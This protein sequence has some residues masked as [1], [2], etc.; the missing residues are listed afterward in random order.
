MGNA[1]FLFIFLIVFFVVSDRAGETAAAKPVACQFF[2]YANA[3]KLLGQK[4]TGADSEENK[5][6]GSQRWNC[7]FTAS[8][9]DGG[10]KL[11]FSLYRDTTEEAARTEFQRIRISNHQGFEDWPGVGD[12]AV[13]H[14]DG[15]NFQL[16]MIRKGPRTIRIKVNPAKGTSL[17]DLKTI[18]A[19]LAGK[20]K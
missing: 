7:T 10:R 6:D 4:V 13:V 9:G 3:E 15:E 20:L 11:Y 14:A 16:V 17:E 12:E 5:A 18:A 1:I 8:S 2:T 19:S